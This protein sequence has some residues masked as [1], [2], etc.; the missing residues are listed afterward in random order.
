[1]PNASFALVFSL[2]LRDGILNL[3]YHLTRAKQTFVFILYH[4]TMH[5]ITVV[6]LCCMSSFY[7]EILMSAIL[8]VGHG[9]IERCFLR[10]MMR[11]LHRGKSCLPNRV[12]ACGQTLVPLAKT[13]RDDV[14][15]WRKSARCQLR[16]TLEKPAIK[17]RIQKRHIFR[18]H[19]M[20][21]NNNNKKQQETTDHMYLEGEKM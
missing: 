11:A 13:T 9:T 2:A 8:T 12:A 6:R 4:C 1:M 19:K 5:R 10:K 3:A 18:Q 17:Q 16:P 7:V 14:E 20:M 15:V 21:N